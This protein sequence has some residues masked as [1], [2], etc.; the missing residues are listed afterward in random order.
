MVSKT[1]VAQNDGLREELSGSEW[2]LVAMAGSGPMTGSTITIAFTEEGLS[3]SA[4]C[5]GYFGNYTLDGASIELVSPLAST[6]MWCEDLM[7][8]E[9][10]FLALLNAAESLT[11]EEDRLTIHTTE[12]DLVFHPPAHKTLEQTLWVLSGI[13]NGEAVVSTWI[14]E[15]ITAEF[16]EGQVTGSAGCNRYFAGYEMD[17]AALTLGPA[18]STRMACDE[19]R[20][21][22]E[23]EFLTALE[24]AV[25]FE[26][27][28]DT[29]TLTDADGNALVTFRAQETAAVSDELLGQVWRW[30]AYEDSAGINDVQV[31]ELGKYTLEFLPDGAYQIQADCN[32]GGGAVEMDGSSL[33]FAPGP[34]TLA[35]CGPDSLDAVFLARLADVVTYVLA[36]GKLHLNLKMDAGNMVF[37]PDVEPNA[38]EYSYTF[39]DGAEGWQHGFA[40]LPADADPEFYQLHGDRSE[41]PGD[42]FGYGY[43]LQGSN[44]SDDLFMFI[45]A[46]VDG[47]TPGAIY[48]VAVAIDLATAVP[49]GLMGIG[50]SPG[51]SV[52][53]KAGVTANEPTVLEDDSGY[54]RMNID[55]GQQAQG[56]ADMLV[57]GHIA[58]AAD[59][60]DG[61]EWQIKRLDNDDQSFR[62]TVG[63]D[64]ALWFIAGTDSGFEGLTDV[65]FNAIAIT[66][67]P[68]G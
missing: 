54:L 24:G 68:A 1:A 18:G 17:D 20:N 23:T 31:G 12:G 33:S 16:N 21:V 44:H 39:E 6:E 43:R 32:R 37:G 47:F 66:L 10:A 53:L 22:R 9:N 14:D 15:E 46:R 42:L 8:Q 61:G 11:L 41:L 62:V 36:D 50:G 45:K 49:E 25:A 60:S 4:G 48:D 2:D 56:G 26:I 13:S 67:T 7:E 55:K 38:A 58:Y 29:L 3:G 63:E 28:R 5:N 19:E 30:L 34:M 51:E 64:G 65:Y 35:A 59:D 27:G 52:Y 57:L 40:D